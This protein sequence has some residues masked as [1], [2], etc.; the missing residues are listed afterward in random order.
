MLGCGDVRLDALGRALS[1]V[2]D[3]FSF[4]CL[5]VLRE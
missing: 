4:V 2:G 1:K 3:S 5:F